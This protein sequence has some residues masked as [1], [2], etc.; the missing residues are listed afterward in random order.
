LHCCTSTWLARGF[1]L[2]ST[3][4]FGLI[5]TLASVPGYW[6]S[7]Y[8][9]ERIGRKPTL[10]AYALVGAAIVGALTDRIGPPNAF[11]FSAVL[12]VLAGSVVLLFGLET[13]GKSLEQIEALT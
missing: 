2:Q 4:T 8:L 1:S 9:I 13:R 6:V 3:L 12:F 10:A 11:T 5:S 7:A